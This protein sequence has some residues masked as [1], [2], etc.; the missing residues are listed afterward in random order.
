MAI[1]ASQQHTG[2][3]CAERGNVEHGLHRTPG[4]SFPMTLMRNKRGMNG[5]SS[6][7]TTRYNK[8]LESWLDSIGSADRSHWCHPLRVAFNAAF[9]A[10][11]YPAW[12]WYSLML[13]AHEDGHDDFSRLTSERL[14]SQ[15]TVAALFFGAAFAA[16][17]GTPPSRGELVWADDLFMLL[18]GTSAVCSLF[19]VVLC[20]TGLGPLFRGLSTDENAK[21]RI[22]A[23]FG[24]S[25]WFFLLDGMFLLGVY[26][27]I[28][29]VT[30]LTMIRIGT[31]SQ[32]Q[33][34]VHES[35]SAMGFALFAFFLWVACV[36]WGVH[37]WN[38]LD[39]ISAYKLGLSKNNENAKACAEAIKAN[40][41]G[42]A[43]GSTAE[44]G[45]SAADPAAKLAEMAFEHA[46]LMQRMQEQMEALGQ[47]LREQQQ[48]SEALEEKLREQ[49]RAIAMTVPCRTF[50]F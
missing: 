32:G 12:T 24:C 21:K 33:V 34:L 44:S 46:K 35:W 22:D 8:F 6:G 25:L 49:E 19:V 43:A 3:T 18:C 1:R 26:T 36:S 10:I 16:V 11:R 5:S 41:K 27:L 40:A 47:T 50:E 14:D 37:A 13:R 45:A 30:M 17:G 9:M 31:F 42:N 20:G 2:F 28:F 4:S 23:Y 7:G 39:P 29:A 15:V 48:Q 38:T